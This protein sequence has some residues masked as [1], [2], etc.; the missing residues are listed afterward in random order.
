MLDILV[1]GLPSEVL[2]GLCLTVLLF[3]ISTVIAVPLGYLY[4]ITVNEYPSLS[5]LLRSFATMI[6]GIPLL[7]L[8]FICSYLPNVSTLLSGVIG[9]IL[10]SFSHVGEIQRGFLLKYPESLSRQTRA[11]GISRARDWWYL[12][13]LWIWSRSFQALVTHWVSLLKDTGALVVLGIGEL[14]TVA[15]ILSESTHDSSRWI[16]VLALTA[17]LYLIASFSLITVLNILSKGSSRHL[18]N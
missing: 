15:K 14:T 8:V 7:L 10:Y 13:P 2:G 16:A 6:R 3:A 9:L 1:F 11:M 17:V 18:L 4:A 12:R 5:F